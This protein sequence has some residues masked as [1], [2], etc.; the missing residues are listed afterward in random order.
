MDHASPPGVD[1]ARPTELF[2]YARAGCGL[3][4]ETRVTLEAL[5]ARRVASGRPSA[6]LVERDIESDPELERAFFTEIPV[7]ELGD[8]RL[9]LAISPAR[10]E[11]LL[12]DVLDR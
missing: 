5:L 8:R 1:G 10:I 7:I 12:A 2:L 3:C 4:D 11:R 6:T 9:T